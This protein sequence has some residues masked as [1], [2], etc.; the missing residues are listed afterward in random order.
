[1]EQLRA[2]WRHAYVTSK[3]KPQGCVLCAALQAAAAPES[4]V[5]HVAQHCFVVMNLY[6]YNSGH[7][8]VSPRRHVGRLQDATQQELA[9]TMSLLQRLERILGD[10][11]KPD[12]MNIGMN[13]GR[14]AGAGVAEHIHMHLVPRWN[15]DTN[16][17]SVVGETRVIPED[18]REA[19]LRLRP[20]FERP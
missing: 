5:V 3:E 4:L 8:M 7:V 6:A 19:C 17:V 12:G 2:P 9:E 10:V 18:P 15:G 1:M 14:A 16:F 11:Y 20:H 13:L